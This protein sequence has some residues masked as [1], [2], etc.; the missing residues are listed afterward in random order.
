MIWV[1]RY[2]LETIR[3]LQLELIS[4]QAWC[5]YR[6]KAML[7]PLT[8]S[9]SPLPFEMV[10]GVVCQ[11]FRFFPFGDRSHDFSSSR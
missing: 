4:A 3:I 10:F 9:Q 7:V 11:M 8:S 6:P 2:I 5:L 1:K